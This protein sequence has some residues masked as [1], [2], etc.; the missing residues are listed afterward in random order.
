MKAHQHA[1]YETNQPINGT[2]ICTDAY[3]HPSTTKHHFSRSNTYIWVDKI[4][5]KLTELSHPTA[6][7]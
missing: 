1:K 2:A 6:T 4:I 3:M 5:L 7:L